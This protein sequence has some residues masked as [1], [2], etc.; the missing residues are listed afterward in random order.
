MNGIWHRKICSAYNGK[1]KT[2]NEYSCQMKTK[3]E[4]P[5]KRKPT[6]TWEYWQRTSLNMRRRRKTF[7][8]VYK[9]NLK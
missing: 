8:K 6:N 7:P 1:R 9:E 5:E 4:R 3:S 2:A